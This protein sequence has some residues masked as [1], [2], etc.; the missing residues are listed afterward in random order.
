MLMTVLTII[1]QLA[2]S[3]ALFLYGMQL[4][5]DGIQ[6]AAGDKLQRTVNFMTRNTFFAIIT[7]MVITVLLQSSS[8]AT[9]MVVSFANA[10]LLGLVQA[11]GVIMG[12]NIGTTLTGW[13]IALAGVS[14]FSILALAVPVFGVGYFMTLGR[15]N[16]TLKSYGESLM[17]FAMIF[18]GLDFL[19]KA[20]PAPSGDILALLQ[21]VS[22][23][24]WLSTLICVAAGTV[25][26]MLIRASSATLAVAIG[27][28]SKGI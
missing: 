9:V 19:A 4:A 27:L 7:G 14:K 21:H 5:S 12:S 3:L 26:T 28:A 13:I 25:F 24:G 23:L 11:V 18:L 17:G 8:A 2:G 1:F 22:G 15:N 16:D 10:G 20:I 6:R